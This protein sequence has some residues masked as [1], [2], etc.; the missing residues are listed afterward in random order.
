MRTHRQSQPSEQA[1]T[2]RDA[3]L[4]GEDLNAEEQRLTRNLWE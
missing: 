4:F 2:A 3:Y 1:V